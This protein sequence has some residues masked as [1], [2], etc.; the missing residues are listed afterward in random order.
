MVQPAA[1]GVKKT[2]VSAL[3]AAETVSVLGTRMTYL[4]LPWFVLVTTGSP[5]KMSV[6]LAVEIVPQ[7][8]LGIPS[9]SL[10]QR[11]G[12]RTTM[13][14]CDFARAPL[15]AA[16]PLLYAAGV[17]S[18]GLLLALVALV[19]CFM[20]PY[21]A[22][23][24]VILP[25][26]VGE[27]ERRMSQANS[28]IEGGTALAAVLGPALAGVLIPFVGAPNV[29]YVD[30]ATYVVSFLLILTFVPR[31]KPV[32]P[33]TEAE[34]GVLAG[35]RFLVHDRLLAPIA[36]VVV[37]FGFLTAGLS[38]GLPVYAYDEF[39]GSSRIAGFFFAA[40][41][42][43]AVVGSILAVA[44]VRKV[45][46]LR[47]SG[48]AVVCFALPVWV[49]PFL[50]PAP[51]VSTALFVSNMFVVLANGPAIA[52]VTA[53]TPENLRA[54]VMTAVIAASSVSVPLG[55]LVAGQ[56]LE[57]W[58]LVPLF[59]I[60]AVGLTGMALVYASIAFRHRELEPA[61]AGVPARA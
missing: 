16:I 40:V 10:V 34:S 30:A 53:R 1:T 18:F 20:P 17:L 59:S 29:L 38:A 28:L 9:G 36:V 25:E 44:A 52:V 14:A 58:G 23:Q 39:D 26:L 8:V 6:V 3:V 42:A 45:S 7:A 47:L 13:L 22:S 43:G 24:R 33:V 60:V 32:A 51:V 12:A 2:A 21:F 56:I 5:G 54:K 15:L 41:G 48:L 50:P 37:G 4:A 57:R 55:F 49:M 35:L 19:G 61:P 27:D 31:R 11:F 46:P